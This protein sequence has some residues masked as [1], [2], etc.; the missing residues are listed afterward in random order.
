MLGDQRLGLHRGGLV[1]ELLG[2]GE[3]A[4]HSDQPEGKD[5]K[6][7][8]A[9]GHDQARGP[10]HPLAGTRPGP[11]QGWVRLAELGDEGPEEAAPEQQ[12]DSRQEEQRGQQGHHDA[13][14]PDE[15]EAAVVVECGGESEN[16]EADGHGG[17]AGQD[18]GASAEQG[19]AH[20]HMAVLVLSQL[21]A[22]TSDEQQGVIGSCPEHQD[23]Q[24]TGALP[25]H[26]QP[27]VTGQQVDDGAGH[28][29]GDADDGERNQPEERAPVGDDE[30][31]CHYGDSG[32][33][34][35]PVYPAEGADQ[36]DDETGWPADRAPHAFGKA[37]GRGG[38]QLLHGAVECCIR[39]VGGQRDDHDRRLAVGRVLGRRHRAM[40]GHRAELG[41][42]GFDL[43][44]ARRRE[45]IVG[46][47]D[48]DG[49]EDLAAR[50]VLLQDHHLR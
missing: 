38:A 40:H 35:R 45:R 48:D 29:I 44:A 43:L 10:G 17:R 5:G 42:V 27:L 26:H 49:R 3:P 9:P 41:G 46:G 13:D 12:Q 30:D 1:A 33:E 47:V 25:V 50:Q 32:Q 37:L 28:L 22:V 15:P 31:E 6:Q 21:L 11:G 34:Q 23:A 19:L 16:Q 39:L 24:D 18:R 2:L 7:H 8:D 4:R 14:G 36:I 20:R